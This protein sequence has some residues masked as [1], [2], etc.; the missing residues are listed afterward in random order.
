MSDKLVIRV[1]SALSDAG[2]RMTVQDVFNHVLEIFQ[3][4]DES[5]PGAQKQVQWRLVGASMNSPF[6]VVA[7]AVGVSADVDVAFYAARQKSAFREN[8]ESLKNGVVP[9]PWST[10]WAREAVSKVLS[11]VGIGETQFIADGDDPLIISPESDIAEGAKTALTKERTVERRFKSQIGSV[12]GVLTQVG[13]HYGHPAIR[14][15]ERKTKSDVWC[16]IP[17]EFRAEIAEQATFEDVWRG[18]RVRVRGRLLYDSG[19][20]VSRVEAFGVSRVCPEAIDEKQI[21]DVSFTRG[22]GA[23]EYLERLREGHL[24]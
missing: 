12:E 6:T 2:D 16:V 9:E 22:M 13:T 4:V 24:D 21:A 19:G 17:E 1:G 20:A 15:V 5:D 3:L 14:V 10:P 7:E 23:V 8:I 18:A 11:R